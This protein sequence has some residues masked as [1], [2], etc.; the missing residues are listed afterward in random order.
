MGEICRCK[1]CRYIDPTETTCYGK[2]WYCTEYGTYE[3]PDE[4]R[5]CNRFKK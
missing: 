4:V 3:W 2:K 5:E 1:Y